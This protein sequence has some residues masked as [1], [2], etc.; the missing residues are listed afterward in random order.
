MPVP[1]GWKVLDPSCRSEL[2][3]AQSRGREFLSQHRLF[4]SHRTGAVVD[5]AMT[6]FAFPPRWH[7]DILRALDHF[8]DAG[9]ERD[10]RL[11]ES[12][13]IVRTR[14]RKDG[15]WALPRGY[16]GRVFFEL[17]K[18]GLPSRWNTLRAL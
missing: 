12:I 16:A 18:A 10:P 8:R 7:Y 3:A 5:P 13:A 4:R 1:T 11:A 2:C 15:W 14:Q 9:A 6:R 17:E